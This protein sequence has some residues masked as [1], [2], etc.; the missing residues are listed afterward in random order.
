[1]RGERIGVIAEG[2]E[3]Y[4]VLKNI[5][6]AFGFDGSEIK[7]I[8]PALR[9]D[10]TDRFAE[11]NSNQEND[12]ESLSTGTFQGV[13][14]ACLG[15]EDGKR[16]DFE[17]AFST[18]GCAN[19][20][21]HVDTA[22]I[23]KHDFVIEIPQKAEN[24]NYSQE[25]RNKIIELINSWLGGEYSNQL[26]YAISIEEIESWCLTAFENKDTVMFADPKQK[27]KRNYD[28]ANLNYKKF[29]LNPKKHKHLFFEELTKH[30]K[31][32]KK[33]ELLKFAEY[34]QSLKDFVN[35]LEGKFGENSDE[36][37]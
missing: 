17:Y 2:K 8:R 22:E 4:G 31:F 18:L 3:D 23:G 25:L 27:L 33:K 30:L 12:L 32:H 35:S 1:M 21:I 6:R 13:K 5:L 10:A 36:L 28:K 16:L 11:A 20:V 37:E 29:R 15:N 14:N 19:M 24:E 34:N 26:F 9:K 7:A